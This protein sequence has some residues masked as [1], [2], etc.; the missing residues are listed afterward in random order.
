MYIKNI[1]IENVGP[2]E[3]L[4]IDLLPSTEKIKPIILVGENGTGKSIFL[5]H[6]INSLITGKGEVFDDVEIELGKV[7]KYRSPNYI[8]SGKTFSY[9]SVKFEFGVE[10]EECQLLKLKTDFEEEFGYTP[11]RKIWNIIQPNEASAFRATF[12]D[13]VEVTNN[14]FKKQCC[15]YFPVNRFEEPAWLNVDNLKSRADYSELKKVSRFSNREIICISP[16]KRNKNWLLDILL[17]RHLYEAK[18]HQVS[19]PNK[20]P[21]QPPQ[22]LSMISGYSGPS[23]KIYE[24]VL[25]ILKVILRDPGNIRLGVG[26]RKN[27]NIEVLKDE[28]RWVPNLFQ[29]ST[30][31]VQLL[32]LFLSILRDYDL[33]EG[34]FNS[35]SD[36]KGVVIIDEIDSHLHTSHQNEVL[37]DLLALFPKVQFIITTHSPFFLMGMEEKFESKNFVILNMPNG[38]QVDASDFSE[39]NAAYE[40]FKET[41]KH[42]EE[43]RT[44]LERHAMPI[45]FVEGDYDIRYI[46]KAAELLNKE[47]ILTRIR[48]KDVGGYGS[49]DKILRAYDNSISEIAPNK[50][51]CLYDCD[52][53]KSDKNNGRVY[54]RIITSFNDNP[55]KKGIENLFSDETILKIES[56]N[57]HFID[58]HN[59]SINRIRGKEVH[60]SAIKYVNK[61][62]KGNMC[63]WLCEYGT[64]DDFVNFEKV[65]NIID[66]IISK[67]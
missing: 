41:T 30:G 2:I 37:P 53:G 7:Y 12:M 33:S 27:R 62:E 34:E 58:I 49:L 52:I 63:N 23:T 18:M 47:D 65:F 54:R 22:T 45:V 61:D 56:Q 29:L 42:R 5:S 51:I 32:N 60:S 43:I 67:D 66:E 64:A 11:A 50:I 1:E 24:A 19:F 38:D 31:E 48:L 44:E 28:I 55:I 46:I 21:D 14:F 26:T 6:I 16:L 10:V 25:K 35:L 36:I 15:L 57:P 8:K 20:N 13:H 3:H 9:S 39:F 59:S 4:K 17:D 40:A